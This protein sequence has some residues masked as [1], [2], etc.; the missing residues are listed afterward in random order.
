MQ[1]AA[2]FRRSLEAMDIAG[3]RAIWDHVSPVPAPASD[4][5]MLAAMHAA[6]TAAESVAFSLRAY[7]HRW[8][9][10]RCLPSLLP[11][12]LKPRAER[13]YPKVVEAVGISVNYKSPHLAPAADFI[14]GEME[15]SVLESFDD[16]VRDP[17]E[18]RARMFAAKLRAEKA[19]FGSFY[20]APAV[21]A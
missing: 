15:L 9:C 8:L 17:V 1:Y 20:R 2:Q 12:H 11:D 13:I 7:S 6:R 10:D 3:V 4:S 21:I 16:K 5:D 14:R 18:V 19:A